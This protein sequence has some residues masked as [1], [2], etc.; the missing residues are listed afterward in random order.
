M[1]DGTKEKDRICRVCK[2]VFTMTAKQI[3]DHAKGCKGKV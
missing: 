3:K 1:A 2:Q